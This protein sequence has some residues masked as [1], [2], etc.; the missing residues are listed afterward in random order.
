[1]W[2]VVDDAENVRSISSDRY[3]AIVRVMD[4]FTGSD[5]PGGNKDLD[6]A[7]LARRGWKCIQIEVETD[8]ETELPKSFPLLKPKP[9]PSSQGPRSSPSG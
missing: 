9:P 4:C 6:D 1:M 3:V 7:A 8:T 5:K 2:A